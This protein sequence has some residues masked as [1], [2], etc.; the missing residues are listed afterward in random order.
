MWVVGYCRTRGLGKRI[1]GRCG[2]SVGDR[3]V[4]K[5]NF[6]VNC[7]FWIFLGGFGGGGGGMKIAISQLIW[8]V[9]D[10]QASLL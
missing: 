10:C 8:E 2:Q 3:G 6:I 7:N 4:V 5:S 1:V 9:G